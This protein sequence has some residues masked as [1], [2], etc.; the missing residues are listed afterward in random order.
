MSCSVTLPGMWRGEHELFS[1][2]PRHGASC[3]VTLPV[4]RGGGEWARIL[5]LTVLAQGVLGVLGADAKT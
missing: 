5:P 1:Y 4:L 3:S 2:T